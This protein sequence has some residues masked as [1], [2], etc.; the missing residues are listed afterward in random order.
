MPNPANIDDRNVSLGNFGISPEVTVVTEATT[1][2]PHETNVQVITNGDGNYNITLPNPAECLNRLVR[3]VMVEFDTD[4]AT[5][6]NPDGTD[7]GMDAVDEHVLLFSDGR[8][9]IELDESVT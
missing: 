1:L 2:K 9:W 5:L 7:R 4:T 6:L 8:I 3:V